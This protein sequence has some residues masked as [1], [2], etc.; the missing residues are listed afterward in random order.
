MWS[1]SE[2]GYLNIHTQIHMLMFAA[3][4]QIPKYERKVAQL[5]VHSSAYWD[6]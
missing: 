6:L 4:R 5:R 1:E 3:V 2:C